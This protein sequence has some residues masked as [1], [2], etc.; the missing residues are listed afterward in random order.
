[1]KG[2]RDW[3]SE[4]FVPKI[5]MQAAEIIQRPIFDR[6]WILGQ[7]MRYGAWEQHEW[8]EWGK[9]GST[10]LWNQVSLS[11]KNAGNGSLFGHFMNEYN[12]YKTTFRKI[13]IFFNQDNSKNSRC[14]L[15]LFGSWAQAETVE[16]RR[17]SCS[18]NSI[19]T[20]QRILNAQNQRPPTK[21]RGLQRKSRSRHIL[22]CR[23]IRFAANYLLFVC[24]G[25]CVQLSISFRK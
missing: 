15:G 10:W 2:F 20:I 9:R 7:R 23:K 8:Y 12:C 22:F 5:W 21:V 4:V 14:W 24:Q 19:S 11:A 16:T 17:G 6:Q 18:K 25:K 13:I 3:H 1:M